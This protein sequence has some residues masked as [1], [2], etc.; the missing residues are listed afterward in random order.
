MRV[1]APLIPDVAL[2]ELPPKKSS[3]HQQSLRL[4]SIDILTV[5]VQ[6][7][8]VSAVQIDGM[9]STE[10]GHYAACCQSAVRAAGLAGSNSQPPPTTMILGAGILAVR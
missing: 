10:T 4:L 6:Q 2:V 1:R 9:G 7:K 5:L 3:L 8:D